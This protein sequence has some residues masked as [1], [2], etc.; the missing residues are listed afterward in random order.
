MFSIFFRLTRTDLPEL[1][2]V[3]EYS[4]KYGNAEKREHS[5]EKN[6]N[7]IGDIISKSSSVLRS[8][9][10]KEKKKNR[11]GNDF[12]NLPL[13]SDNDNDEDDSIIENSQPTKKI[14]NKKKLR[15]KLAKKLSDPTSGSTNLSRYEAE[16][17]DG[18][19]PS[20]DAHLDILDPKIGVLQ[21]LKKKHGMTT[22]PS[23]RETSRFSEL[24]E[25]QS[26][27]QQVRGVKSSRSRA[28]I[29]RNSE[30]DEAKV[31]RKMK[32]LG[33]PKLSS[34]YQSFLHKWLS[35]VY[36]HGCFRLCLGTNTFLMY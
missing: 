33:Y 30:I 25:E 21:N 12:D 10:S 7:S 14:K 3:G 24:L 31:N 22:S 16:K 36:F 19:K 27:S 4:Y 20:N 26:P 15:T 5:S 9:G 32:S 1:Q 8:M 6:K 18:F 2:K 13:I 29:L 17:L 11:K 34:Y 23:R 35:K 28:R